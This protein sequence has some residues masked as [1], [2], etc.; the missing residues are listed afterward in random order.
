[1][2][3]YLKAYSFVMKWQILS[4]KPVL[5]MAFIVQLLI[6]GAVI[7]GLGFMYPKIDMLSAKYIVT[8]AAVLALATLGLVMVPQTIAQMKASKAFDYLW[9]LPI[10][11]FIFLLSDFSFWAIIV[12][13]GVAATLLM[14]SLHYGFNLSISPLIV[15][16]FLLVALTAVAVGM[17]VAHLSPSPV[18]TGI[19]TNITVF[20]IFFFSPINF[21]PERLPEWLQ[22]IHKILPVMYM[23]DLV[24]GTV[25]KGLASNLATAFAVVGMWCVVS[26]VALYRVFS[27]RQ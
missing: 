25:T 23:A 27:M 2:S 19:L 10:P 24:R 7:Y 11:R 12:L 3:K 20:I 5:P 6:A 26:F 22:I 16:A 13:P 21:P 15:P 9:S 14:G 1:M 4:L 8:G 18:L 17:S